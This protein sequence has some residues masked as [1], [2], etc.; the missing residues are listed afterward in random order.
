VFR[1]AFRLI[2]A[3]PGGFWDILIPLV[4]LAPV[5]LVL[6]LVSLPWLVVRAARRQR[7]TR[8]EQDLPITLELLATLA[9]GGLAFDAALDRILSSQPEDRP[10]A[11]EFRLYQ[12]ELLAGR[13]RVQCLRRLSRR[14]DIPAFTT[15]I[16]A[17]VQAEQVGAG[18]AQVLRVQVEDF[19]QRRR[20]RALR[21]AMTLPV[22]LIFPLIICFLPGLFVALLGPAFY[23]IV[24]FL[25]NFTRSGSLR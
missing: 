10:L 5:M 18:I 24:E 14:L 21:L 23:Q 1:P 7:V 8:A 3:L 13:P 15:F 22:K 19:R 9:E 17:L 16:S 20:E 12:V 6:S 25:D 2:S 4:Y 11:Q